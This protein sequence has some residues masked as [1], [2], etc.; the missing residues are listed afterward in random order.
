MLG[1]SMRREHKPDILRQF[2][3]LVPHRSKDAGRRPAAINESINCLIRKL[4]PSCFLRAANNI[5]I[6]FSYASGD[7]G[8]PFISLSELD[9]LLRSQHLHDVHTRRAGG[10]QQRRE[11]RRSHQKYRRSRDR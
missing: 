8:M 11:D 4:A 2:T 7:A 9:R 10:G 1:S 3:R 6:C 5:S